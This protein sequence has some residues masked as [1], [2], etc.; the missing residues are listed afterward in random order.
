MLQHFRRLS[1]S[2]LAA[3][4]LPVQVNPFPTNPCLHSQVP[5]MQF[6]FM[7]Q[8]L[9]LST[10]SEKKMISMLLMHIVKHSQLKS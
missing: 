9:H 8:R 6:A 4:Y 1:K 2:L 5:L 10:I 3:F 7:S